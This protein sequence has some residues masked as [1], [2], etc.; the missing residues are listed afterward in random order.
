MEGGVPHQPRVVRTTSDDVWIDQHAINISDDDERHFCRPYCRREGVC[1]PRR[2]LDI[3]TGLVGTSAHHANSIGAFAKEQAVLETREVRVRTKEDRVSGG[4][5]FRRAS[6]DGPSEGGGGSGVADSDNKER[7]A[8]IPWIHEL[9]QA[10]Y[11]GLLTHCKPFV[12][13]DRGKG[14]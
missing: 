7:V 14:F 3:F 11:S 12:H 5:H 2:H 13:L 8:A 9:L 10:F 4:H 1:L 6:G